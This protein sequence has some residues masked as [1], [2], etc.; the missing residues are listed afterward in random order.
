MSERQEGV[1]A[2]KERKGNK[3][4]LFFLPRDM[5]GSNLLSFYNESHEHLPTLSA[6]FPSHLWAQIKA[7]P[8]FH[9]EIVHS[10]SVLSEEEL[11]ITIDRFKEMEVPAQTFLAFEIL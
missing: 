1:R 7:Q 4:Y 5:R 11:N 9:L 3:I 10:C 6:H 8:Q 2:Q